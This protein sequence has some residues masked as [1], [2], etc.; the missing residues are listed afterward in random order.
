[1]SA[2]LFV[3]VMAQLVYRIQFE[4][5]TADLDD[6]TWKACLLK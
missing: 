4:Q 2:A 1:M 3:L 6:A 5:R